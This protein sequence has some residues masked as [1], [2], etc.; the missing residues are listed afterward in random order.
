LPKNVAPVIDGI[1]LQ[2]PG[3]RSQAAVVITGQAANVILKQPAGPNPAGTVITTTT[4]FDQPPQGIYQKGYAT[5]LWTAH[6]DNDDELRYTAYF[7]G[8]NQRDWL[9]LKD[10]LEQKFYSWDATAMPDGAYY[11]KIVASDSPSNPPN[12]ALKTERESER[13]EIDN[14][15]PV[16]E[17]LESVGA[18]TRDG[19]LPPSHTIIAKFTATDATSG[20]EKAQYSVDGGEWILLAPEQ[21]I[22]DSKSESYSFSVHGLPP[23]EHTIAVRAYDRFDN[24]GAGKMTTTI[25]R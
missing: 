11:L 24:V 9:L 5:V 17:H 13:F 10:N 21:G 4:K 3:T 19:T 25:P 18:T 23:G 1:A 12:A 14:T 2:E 20:I 16:I 15:P 6:D 8:E 7:R 22:S